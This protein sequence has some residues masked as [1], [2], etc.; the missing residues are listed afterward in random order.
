[1]YHQDSDGIT[2]D[3][4]NNFRGRAGGMYSPTDYANAGANQYDTDFSAGVKMRGYQQQSNIAAAGPYYSITDLPWRGLFLYV[5]IPLAILW[6]IVK[7]LFFADDMTA[8]YAVKFAKQ[9][10]APMTYVSQFPALSQA[11]ANRTNPGASSGSL[12]QA[13]MDVK[14]SILMSSPDPFERSVKKKQVRQKAKQAAEAKLVVLQER[15]WACMVTPECWKHEREHY[16]TI[17]AEEGGEFAYRLNSAD[18]LSDLGLFYMKE[19][20]Y[21]M[22]GAYFTKMMKIWRDALALNPNHQQAKKYVAIAESSWRIRF[23]LYLYSL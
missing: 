17:L 10:Y 16:P 22:N 8:S 11:Y 18:A 6:I 12:G 1:M 23:W 14:R 7:C 13:V 15:S 5:G 4:Y 2:R 3:E 19:N 9:H 21:L 20:I